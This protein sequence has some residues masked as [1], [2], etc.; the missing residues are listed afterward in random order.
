MRNVVI[1][2][3][4]L[5]LGVIVAGSLESARIASPRPVATEGRSALHAERIQQIGWQHDPWLR[6]GGAAALHLTRMPAVTP[7]N[8]PL[9]INRGRFFR[10]SFAASVRPSRSPG[11]PVLDN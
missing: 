10:D 11:F 3:T 2:A 6:Q 4:L 8:Q 7:R 5:A 9:A 1:G